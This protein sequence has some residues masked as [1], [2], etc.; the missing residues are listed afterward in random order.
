MGMYTE[1]FFRAQLAKEAPAEVVD[2]L[3]YTLE[4]G[5]S[6]ATIVPFDD[7]K[8]FQCRRW[9]TLLMG[10]SS[11]EFP[12]AGYS[13]FEFIADEGFSG[14]RIIIHASLKDYD[15]ETD[16]FI[17][18][19]SPYLSAAPGDFLGYTLYEDTK[20]NYDDQESPLLIF[21]GGDE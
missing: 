15:S 20:N 8:F 1:F 9:D 4:D 3:K 6:W 14:N 16:H 2:Y 21:M 19:I 17:D 7:H 18:W 10:G 5:R 13:K 12:A 11:L